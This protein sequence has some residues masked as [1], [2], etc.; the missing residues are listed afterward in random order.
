MWPAPD[1]NGEILDPAQERARKDRALA[2]QTELRNDVSLGK[3][4]SADD[5]QAAWTAMVVTARNHFLGLPSKLRMLV[6]R[7]YQDKVHGQA[8]DI[9][10][11]ALNELADAVVISEGDDNSQ[12]P[13]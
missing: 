5:A 1:A 13:I 9:V 12:S 10:H 7:E 11:N 2:I 3:L 8:E 6:P 4:V